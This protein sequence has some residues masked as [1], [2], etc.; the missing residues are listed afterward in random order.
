MKKLALAVAVPLILIG[1][2]TLYTSTQVESTARDAVEQANLKLRD[3]SLGAGAE[4]RVSMLSFDRGLL[5][6]DARYQI[7]VEVPDDEGNTQHY[8]VLVQ[9]RLEHGPFP[10]SRLSRGQL[11]PVAAQSHLQL[12]RTPLTEAL[13]VAASGEAPLRGDVAI[14]Y[15]GGQHGEL[16][17]AALNVMQEAGSVQIAAAN[18]R[19]DVADQANTVRMEGELPEVKIDLQHADSGQPV[20]VSL[21]G[22]ELSADKHGYASGFGQGPSAVKVERTEIRAGD[23]PAVVIQDASVE[24]VLSRGERGLDQSVAYRIGEV[25][26]RGQTF[27]NL[28][29]VFSLRNLE[30]TSLKALLDSYKALLDS[31]PS[32]EDAIANI[33]AAQQNELQAKTLQVLEHKPTL[34]LDEFSFETASGAARL[35]LVLDLQGPSAA[36][37]SDPNMITNLI[38]ALETDAGIDLGLVRDIANLVVQHQEGDASDPVVLQQETDAATE[39]FS[40]LAIDSGW[41][42]LQDDRLASSLRY[43][44]DRVILNGREMS[45]QDFIGFAWSSA[46]GAGLLGQ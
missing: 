36:T 14:G 29:L 40:G 31:G 21:R 28:A 23:Q 16:R 7:D 6:S 10:L 5:S 27:R 15:D 11:M 3:M 41:F 42:Q 2:A 1:A 35:S 24:E 39:L 22:I 17:S 30:E 37:T 25:S 12:E 32:Q 18:I 44:D 13:F 46:L 33:T 9:D 19:F 38:A 4:A 34:A 45:V 8:A 43:A 26:A 20:H